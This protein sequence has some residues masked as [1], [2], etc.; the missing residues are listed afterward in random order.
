V[1]RGATRAALLGSAVL[2][3]ASVAIAATPTSPVAG[4]P[5]YAKVSLTGPGSTGDASAFTT[6]SNGVTMPISGL[7]G[8]VKGLTAYFDQYGNLTTKVTG[9]ASGATLG[10][11]SGLPVT[12]AAVVNLVAGQSQSI[13]NI[14]STMFKAD[15]TIAM[16]GTLIVHAGANIDGAINAAGFAA[17]DDGQNGSVDIGVSSNA[18]AAPYIAWDG[19]GQHANVIEQNDQPGRLNWLAG[20][21]LEMQLTKTLNY[22]GVP[23]QLL[24]LASTDRSNNAITAAVAGGLV[25]TEVSR[26]TKAEAAAQAGA[27]ASV[28]KVG[29]VMTGNLQ[30]PVLTATQGVYAPGAT[31]GADVANGSLALGVTSNPAATP[32]IVW[33]GA[34]VANNLIEQNDLA[35]RLNYTSG[36]ILELQLSK[37]GNTMN[38]PLQVPV[39]ASTDRSNN[40]VSAAFAGGLFDSVPNQGF[41]S[42]FGVAL[43]SEAVR[44][45]DHLKAPDFILASDPVGDDTLA[46]QR[47]YTAAQLVMSAGGDPI[48]EFPRRIIVTTMPQLQ[49]PVGRSPMFVSAPGGSE[50]VVNGASNG[51]D[52]QATYTGS[53]VLSSPAVGDFK[54]TKGSGAP[55][56]YDAVRIAGLPNS[57]SPGAVYGARVGNENCR[58]RGFGGGTP[59]PWAACVE[60]VD[61]NYSGVESVTYAY[62][63][64]ANGEQKSGVGVLYTTTQSSV[65]GNY[66]VDHFIGNVTMN[67]GFAGVLTQGHVEGVRLLSGAIVG[68]VYGVRCPAWLFPG[69]GSYGGCD[70]L[71][72]TQTHMNVVLRGIYAEYSANVQTDSTDYFV[73]PNNG[74]ASALAAD[75]V[76][77]LTTAALNPSNSLNGYSWAGV[78]CVSCN[79]TSVIGTS[80]YGTGAGYSN[81]VRFTV[82]PYGGIAAPSSVG[83]GNKV[84]GIQ[85]FAINGYAVHTDAAIQESQVDDNNTIGVSGYELG[86]G[87]EHHGNLNA[88]AP[89]DTGFL[90]GQHIVQ[91]DEA[92]TGKILDSFGYEVIGGVNRAVLDL[93]NAGYTGTAQNVRIELAPGTGSAT[94][95]DDGQ[96]NFSAGAFNFNADVTAAGFTATALSNFQAELDVSFGLM[97]I[98]GTNRGVLDLR[99]AGY[100]GTGGNVRIELAPSAQGS[101]TGQGD[102]QLNISDALTNF[103]SQVIAASLSTSAPSVFAGFNST[104]E[105]DFGFGLVRVGGTNR[106]I[107]DFRGA[108]YT[109]TGQNVRIE[110]AP[111]VQGSPTGS[112]DGQ[113]NFSASAFNFNAPI[114]ALG[115]ITDQS[116]LGVAAGSTTAFFAGNTSRRVMLQGAVGATLSNAVSVT[117]PPNPI[118]QQQFD[119]VGDINITNFSVIAPANTAGKTPVVALAPT[120]F[121]YNNPISFIYVAANQVWEPAI[122][123]GSGTVVA[124]GTGSATIVNPTT[125]VAGSAST[126]GLVFAAAN[127]RTI[128]Y[129]PNQ[130]TTFSLSGGAAG[131][132]QRVVLIIRQPS[133]GGF[134]I[135]LPSNVKWVSGSAPAVDESSGHITI[136]NLGTDDGGATYL[137]G[138]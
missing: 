66:S 136:L 104:A 107:L 52:I 127:D 75:A 86:A 6:T 91:G 64:P 18:A 19:Q 53:T 76:L 74:A 103:N 102:G 114:A 49:M 110:L 62:T 60:L 85:A 72:V 113:L 42:T 70:G 35:G 14:M 9:D 59:N 117:L 88:G 16:S 47:L 97:R 34:G 4:S 17:G 46:I 128:D 58:G 93:R 21:V 8:I 65:A 36:G 61:Q 135:T 40:V 96:L 38:V 83:Y 131:Q 77:P 98:G 95:N 71:Y 119:I 92:P 118:D 122:G 20:G 120:S 43:R 126:Y 29:D 31:L 68:S 87:T 3:L 101:T 41:A 81:A 123:V 33:N 25:D 80:F 69:G 105:A 138:F 94:G 1:R 63:G 116:G 39:V 48:L 51:I 26:A 22:M 100:T 15:G 23:L 56:G 137:G 57:V 134:P 10:T 28:K 129:T 2:L 5:T 106:G 82:L 112:N 50:I 79:Y 27:D 55:I 13:A 78:D 67:T 12:G 130:A 54:V 30:A 73:S 132:F 111:L 32:Y 24:P 121:A 90:N 7:Q 84:S 45:S 125:I 109:G 44:E 11:A 89:Y 124:G 133:S 99:S 115:L 37:T 108:G